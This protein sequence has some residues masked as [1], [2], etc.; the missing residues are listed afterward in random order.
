MSKKYDVC[1]KVSEYTDRTTGETKT[2]YQN[3]GVVMEGSNGPYMLLN[4]WFNPA[5]MP[6]PEGRESLLVSLFEPRDRQHQAPVQ[7]TSSVDDYTPF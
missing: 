4:R 3:I 7:H 6:N 1:V 2:R 5:G